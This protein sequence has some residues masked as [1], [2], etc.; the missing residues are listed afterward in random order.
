MKTIPTEMV[1]QNTRQSN[2]TL[3]ASIIDFSKVNS[4]DLLPHSKKADNDLK[5]ALEI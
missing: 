3:N 4:V 5:N 2:N 1:I